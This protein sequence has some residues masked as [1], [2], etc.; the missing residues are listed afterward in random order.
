MVAKN[1]FDADDARL[2]AYALGE[3]DESERAEVE[4]LLASNEGARKFVDELR[5][6]ANELE[7]ELAS[8]QLP[9]LTME[10][11][12]ALETTA[13]QPNPP[14]TR[15]R[16]LRR[17]PALAASIGFVFAFAGIA[18]WIVVQKYRAAHELDT[19]PFIYNV[20]DGGDSTTVASGPAQ[21][22]TLESL[23]G[24]GYVG[25]GD[26]PRAAGNTPP[27]RE[28]IPTSGVDELLV[29][30]AGH[31]A[32][33]SRRAGSGGRAGELAQNFY[34]GRA[35]LRDDASNTESYDSIAENIFKLSRDDA[36]S[37][38]SI[39]VD[40]ASYANVRRFLNEGKRPPA[41]AVRIEELI[42]YFRY[43]Y[44]QP[45]GN[46][47]FSTT[48]DVATCP[49]ARDHLLVRIGLRGREVPVQERP[50]S[51]LVFLIDVSGSMQTADKLPLLVSSLR[52]LVEQLDAR[53]HV[54]LCVYAGSSG[55]V[56][57]STSNKGA[58]LAALEQLQAGGS[59]NGGAGIELAYKTAREHFVEG[60]TNRVILCTDGDFNVGTSSES[61]LVSL[62][63][64]ER[65]SG[66]FLSVLGF[67][68]GNLQ[69]SKMEK[70]ADKGNGNYAYVDSLNEAHKV[71]VEQIGGTLVTIAK[72]VK[73]QVEFNP[74]AVQAWRLVGYE[75]R[76]LAH[77]DFND[78]RKDAGEIGAGH[79]VTALYE[80]VP[81]GVAFSAP[82]V[83]ASRYQEAREVTASAF[84]GELMFVKL[85][86]KQPDGDTSQLLSTPVRN[87]SVPFDE[88]PLDFRFA[89][90]VAAFGMKLRGS[91]FVADTTFEWIRKVALESAGLD[92][93]G[94][95]REFIA[96]VERAQALRDGQ[97][98]QELGYFDNK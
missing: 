51:N 79:T 59:T 77:Q 75:N 26:R 17:S 57:D 44:P 28:S 46:V 30:Q 20:F 76:V 73:I 32:Y 14:A 78:D 52:M 92:E 18:G 65:A 64:R 11:R 72:D 19:S 50:P 43:D 68:T 4:R 49:W 70:L 93:S 40:T 88:A 95:R 54:A 62:I 3:L 80:L 58:I 9:E 94:Y 8:E 89:T 41:G 34:E 83:D 16:W 31:G 45:S 23:R 27:P 39:D 81:V 69:D 55:L 85:R 56:L 66:V 36:L 48:T 82:S 97:R 7:R 47:P 37:T 42:N 13:Q 84:S 6:T 67:G 38:F 96:L 33:S 53:D 60:G 22:P 10:Q 21:Q 63:E 35:A 5:A 61:E 98:L 1:D 87:A 74:A 24:L 15:K 29:G 25:A 86:Y 90:S 71:F 12:V 2:S 91:A